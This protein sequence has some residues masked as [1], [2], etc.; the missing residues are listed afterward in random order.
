[1]DVTEECDLLKP[2]EEGRVVAGSRRPG[3]SGE[4]DSLGTKWLCLVGTKNVRKTQERRPQRG[5]EGRVRRGFALSEC[6]LDPE[7][8]GEPLKNSE[9]GMDT[10]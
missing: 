2:G 9:Q 4:A 10:I 3:G 1:M 6:Q 5:S 8:P 7:R